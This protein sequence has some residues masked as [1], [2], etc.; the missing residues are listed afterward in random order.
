MSLDAASAAMSLDCIWEGDETS[1]TAVNEGGR[2]PR[3]RQRGD[4]GRRLDPEVVEALQTRGDSLFF[5]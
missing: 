1:A 2:P 3:H 4:V 5:S